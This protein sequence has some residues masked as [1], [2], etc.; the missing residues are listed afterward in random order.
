M[1]RI[2]RII[3]DVTMLPKAYKTLRE[4]LKDVENIP[5]D[6]VLIVYV[7][8]SWNASLFDGDKIDIS[9]DRQFIRRLQQTR[10]QTK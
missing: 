9:Y 10:L 5:D 1:S 8:P 2:Y 4:A 7:L 3:V 6:D